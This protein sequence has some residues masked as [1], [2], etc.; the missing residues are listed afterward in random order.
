[1]LPHVSIIVPTINEAGNLPGLVERIAAA[2]AAC[3]YEI[4]VIDDESQDGTAEVCREL[5]RTHPLTLY[6]RPEPTGGLSGAVLYGFARARGDILVVMDADLQ[7]PPEVLPAL[8]AP[9][10][11][12]EADIVIGSRRAPGS[13]IAGPWGLWRRLN[14]T[15]S[16]WLA[17]PLV[18]PVRD[19]LAGFFAI[20]RATWLQARCLNPLG[21]KIALE[22]MCKCPARQ[23]VEIPIEFGMRMHG[24]SKLRLAQQVGYIRHLGRLYLSRCSAAQPGLRSQPKRGIPGRRGSSSATAITRRGMMSALQR[25]NIERAGAELKAIE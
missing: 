13:S 5:T 12:R 22:L 8:I 7:H 19:P 9:V 3:D 20:R 17:A 15:I 4:L 23:I 18:G 21:Y 1:M 10:S 24:E 25:Q 2:M 6:V 11:A 16:R 14:S